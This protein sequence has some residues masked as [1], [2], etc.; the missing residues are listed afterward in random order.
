MLGHKFLMEAKGIIN[1]NSNEE[2]RLVWIM[3][4]AKLI[5]KFEEALAPLG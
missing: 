2:A 3:L 1:L 4:N 5:D